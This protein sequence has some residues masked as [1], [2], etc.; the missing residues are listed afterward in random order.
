MNSRNHQVTPFKNRQPLPL[1]A[2]RT[3]KSWVY[4]IKCTRRRNPK[5]LPRKWSVKLQNRLS[6]AALIS[7][8]VRYSKLNNNCNNKVSRHRLQQTRQWRPPVQE[9]VKVENNTVQ[10]WMKA[11][12]SLCWGQIWMVQEIWMEA[13]KFL[14]RPKLAPSL[15]PGKSTRKLKNRHTLRIFL[16]KSTIK[17][18]GSKVRI[19]QSYPKRSWI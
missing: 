11:I 8:T 15:N 2:E 13:S 10:A 6:R 12:T 3:W 17:A 19:I 1:R 18:H 14:V 4:K 5:R 16:Q 7:N 9:A